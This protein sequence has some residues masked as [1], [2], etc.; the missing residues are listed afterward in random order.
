M[1]LE[2]R[3]WNAPARVASSEAVFPW[4]RHSGSVGRR[5]SRPTVS[6]WLVVLACVVVAF[7]FGLRFWALVVALIAVVMSAVGGAISDRAKEWFERKPD[8]RLF[9]GQGGE[10]RTTVT[11]RLPPW[12]FDL[13]RVVLNEVGRLEEEARAYEK[14]ARTGIY[15]TLVRGAVSLW[16][17]RPSNRDYEN[18]W[19]TFRDELDVYAEDLREWLVEYGRAADERSRTLELRLV[20]MSAPRGAYAESVDLEIDLPEGVVMVD[21]L[22]TV[23][24]QPSPPSYEPPQP[25]DPH[26]FASSHF[27]RIMPITPIFPS[28]DIGAKPIP[29][30]GV[31][32]RTVHT[33]L[34]E[35]HNGRRVE[36]DEP[37]LVRAPGDGRF[38]LRWTFYSKSS[39]RH[40]RGALELVVPTPTERPAFRKLHG[41]VS[42]LDVPIVGDDGKVEVEARTC[43]PPLGPTER[44]ESSAGDSL[45]DRMAGVAEYTEWQAL[46][47]GDESDDVGEVVRVRRVS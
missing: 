8:L 18:A 46:G 42:Y 21:D 6:A 23:S 45:L 16:A 31:T 4:K 7:A 22:P 10:L 34:G 30:W 1:T 35:L 20:V 39:R 40:C 13:E 19:A 15:S 43:D 2:T 29:V 5:V 9:V 38:E 27:P 37:L 47:L 26:E 41:I 44:P 28:M 36:I 12:P 33:R 3:M 25:R 32:D 11:A 17:I 24:P 14:M